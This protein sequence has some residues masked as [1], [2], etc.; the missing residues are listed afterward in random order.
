MS[1]R[2]AKWGLFL[3][4]GIIFIGGWIS[5]SN[6]ILPQMEV[7]ELCQN[8]HDV[9]SVADFL[10]KG[11]VTD[12]TISYQDKLQKAIDA[13]AQENGTLV[14]PP[15]VYRLD[16]SGLRIHSNLTLWMYGAVFQIDGRCNTDGQA[17]LGHNVEKVRFLGGEIVGRNDVWPTG[18]NIRGIYLTGQLKNIRIQDMYIHDLSS[19][20][21]GIFGEQE[22]LACEVW[23]KDTVVENCCNYY[24]DYLSQK[25]G[26]EKGSERK[27][28]GLIA[29]YFVQD[30]V[31][32]ACRF[33][34]SRSDGTH[35]Y[36]CRQGQFVH[37]KVYSSQM[38]GYFLETCMH[39]MASDNIVRENGSRGVTIERG[40]RNCT[41]TGNYVG[42]SGREGLWA[43]DC[44]GLIISAN[45]FDRNG[46]KPNGNKPHQI[47]NAN[48]T[49]NEAS[50][51]PTKSPTEDYIISDNI[52]YT[53]N[54]QI[55]AIHVDSDKAA[56]IVI[57]NNLLRG[58]NQRILIDGDERGKVTLQDNE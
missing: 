43:P 16:E 26:P 58:E 56:G 49:V 30:F 46:L 19:N 21:I 42:N 18:V 15:I 27:D 36:K 14:F 39:V 24:G 4:M 28:Q 12:G 47:W 34:K 31:V 25:P 7:N 17:F 51:D 50:H 22:K 45:I 54:S 29:F 20:G 23:I 32:S 57:K 55:A 35:F 6:S 3:T 37:N 13:A 8:H 52:F 33:E 41:L 38:G 53:S 9:L 5:Q 48:I 1:N 2:N 10:P 40:S 44:I 11:Y